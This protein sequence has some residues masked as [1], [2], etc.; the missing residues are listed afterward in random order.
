MLKLNKKINLLI[1]EEE[2][3]DN[4]ADNKRSQ[5][6][7]LIQ[8]LKNKESVVTKNDFQRLHDNAIELEKKSIQ[9][10]EQARNYQVG[11]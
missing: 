1:M 11:M 5:W 6:L 3:K 4:Q 8:K 2:M 9:A 10:Y 7:S